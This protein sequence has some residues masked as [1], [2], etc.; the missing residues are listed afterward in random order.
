MDLWLPKSYSLAVQK[1][2]QHVVFKGCDLFFKQLN[3]HSAV[4][5]GS[6]VFES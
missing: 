2:L 5:E 6:A 3:T 1:S 4:N